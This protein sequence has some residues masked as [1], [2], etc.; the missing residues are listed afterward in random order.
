MLAVLLAGEDGSWSFASEGL[1][2]PKEARFYGVEMA[3]FDGD[4]H[5]DIAA[6]NHLRPGIWLYRGNGK[7]GFERC[8]ETGL[9]ERRE[10]RG[11]GLAV[12]DV[13]GDARLDL[14]AGF[15]RT[16]DG[17]VEVWLQKAR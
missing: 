5:A 12:A 11:W 13:N 16:G 17:S 8:T 1:P 7:G 6:V 4:G 9:P 14:V 2:G 10:G 15:G 3:D